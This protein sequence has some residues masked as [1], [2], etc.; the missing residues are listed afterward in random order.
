MASRRYAR[1]ELLATTVAGTTASVLGLPLASG[2]SAG[3]PDGKSF[4][5][6][7]EPAGRRVIHGAGQS[8]DAFREYC[9]AVGPQHQPM[10]Y[11][12]YFGLRRATGGGAEQ[13]FEQLQ[14]QLDS[15]S[16]NYLVPQLGLSMT[17]DGKPEL[18][19][20]DRVAA[21]EY[22]AEIKAYCAGLRQ[23]ARPVFLRIGYEFNGPWNGYL[24]DSYRSAWRRIVAALREHGL[25]EVATVWCFEPGGKPNYMDFYPGDEHVD[26]WSIDLFSAGHFECPPAVKFMADAQRRGFPVMIGEST[27]RRIG[28]LDG[29]TSWERW[30]ALYFQFI[31]RHE[32]VKAFCYISWDWAKYPKWG[33]WGD[34]RIQANAEVLARW[35]KELASDLYLHGADAATVKKSL[36][37]RG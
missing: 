2:L 24:P 6:R 10:L 29:E 4:G 1:R 25:E 28:V 31:R 11:M 15:Y 23:L 22:D 5:R 19:Y 12:S 27:P 9:E 30:F 35:K 26:W 37:L 33:D 7:L 13:Y 8:P 32:H 34:A 16:P 14:R 21:G 20:E 18:R 36:G 3:Q 17:T